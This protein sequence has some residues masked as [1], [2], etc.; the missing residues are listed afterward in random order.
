MKP[1]A[2]GER[3][4]G[5][6]AMIDARLWLSP[7]ARF[8]CDVAAAGDETAITIPPGFDWAVFTDVLRR[9]RL[10]LSV[11]RR[12]VALTGLPEEARERLKPHI[13]NAVLQAMGQLSATLRAVAVLKGAGIEVLAFKGC[14]LSQQLYGDPFRRASGDIDLLVRPQARAAAA[15]ALQDAGWRPV[16]S[17][18]DWLDD[19]AEISFFP[20][21]KGAII[22]LHVRLAH[23]EAQCPLNLLR[24]FDSAVE[25]MIGETAVRT[26]SPDVG[27]AY[28]AL[29][30]TRHFCRKLGWLHDIAVAARAWPEVWPGAL[31]VSEGI[32]A[33]PRLRLVA[34]LAQQL[35]AA[36]PPIPSDRR[37]LHAAARALPA[38]A[39]IFSGLPPLDDPDA[40]RRVGLWRALWWDLRLAGSLRAGFG[41]I[42]QRLRPRRADI[43][44]MRPRLGSRAF[45]VV[46]KCVRIISG[47]YNKGGPAPPSSRP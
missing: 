18:P 38:L 23:D 28:L 15:A 25:V 11:G 40:T 13:K 7:E 1:F 47:G 5:E 26:L 21:G 39:P 27:L 8:I 2:D 3:S 14:V 10:E 45:W 12:I 44:E 24:P 4:V 16:R 30:A 43:G 41:V 34:L 29:H 9:H 31:A 20:E 6:P 35:F 46:K 32:G 17:V 37:K 42:A 33:A 19:G 22:D 36:P